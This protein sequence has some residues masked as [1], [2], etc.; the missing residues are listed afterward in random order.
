MKVP[1]SLRK[2]A[3][4]SLAD[5]MPGQIHDPQNQCSRHTWKGDV[6]TDGKVNVYRCP[7]GHLTWTIHA[8]DGVTPFAIDCSRCGKPAQSAFYS[9]DQSPTLIHGVWS[10]EPNDWWGNR[11]DQD[12]HASK[13]GVFLYAVPHSKQL[14]HDSPESSEL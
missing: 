4:L 11:A 14:K 12:N 8:D 10:K 6:P 2:S 3:C 5:S 13:G 1:K 7:D 9:C